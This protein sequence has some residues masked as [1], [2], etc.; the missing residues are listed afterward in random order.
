MLSDQR[1]SSRISKAA[2]ERDFVGVNRIVSPLSLSQ[3]PETFSRTPLSVSQSPFSPSMSLTLA[4]SRGCPHAETLQ[5]FL[6][7]FRR[8]AV[9]VFGCEITAAERRKL[10][11]RSLYQHTV[12]KPDKSSDRYPF[13]G[14]HLAPIAVFT[15][16]SDPPLASVPVRVVVSTLRR[17]RLHGS[18]ASEGG[19]SH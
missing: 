14:V 7:Y 6:R 13:S 4:L 18:A 16:F 8:L 1:T 19:V 9:N 11:C 12:H 5:V 2:D 15:L 10:Y 17:E 3:A